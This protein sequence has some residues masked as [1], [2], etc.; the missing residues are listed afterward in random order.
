MTGFDGRLIPA[1]CS[2]HLLRSH[3][4]R[5]YCLRFLWLFLWVLW[6]LQINLKFFSRS[7]FRS[8]TW[9][10]DNGRFFFFFWRGGFFNFGFAFGIGPLNNRF[11]FFKWWSLL[12]WWLLVF[13][14]R[15]PLNS[16]RLSFSNGWLHGSFTLETFNNFF[17]CKSWLFQ[18]DFEFKGILFWDFDFLFETILTICLELCDKDSRIDVDSSQLVLLICILFIKFEIKEDFSVFIEVGKIEVELATSKGHD[19]SSIGIDEVGLGHYFVFVKLL[20]SLI[21][22]TKYPCRLKTWI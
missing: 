8:L 20:H 6:D 17:Q 7:F 9:F 4:W 13:N 5:H 14:L 10:L 11:N 15:I 18:I 2:F 12:K 16:G 1:W 19:M 3:N 22:R 21:I